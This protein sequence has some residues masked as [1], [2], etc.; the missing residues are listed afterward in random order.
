[1]SFQ[2]LWA[3]SYFKV[4]Q[5]DS[6]HIINIIL[7][8]MSVGYL[9]GSCSGSFLS[10]KL[11][12]CRT[13]PIRLALLLLLL[14]WSAITIIPY[15]LNTICFTFLM[16]LIGIS[17]GIIS[18][19]LY[20]IITDIIPAQNQGLALGIVNPSATFG[21]FIFQLITGFILESF[22]TGNIYD[23]NSFLIMME[24]CL[25]TLIISLFI[26]F[27]LK[28]TMQLQYEINN[29]KRFSLSNIKHKLQHLAPINKRHIN[30]L[31]YKRY[32][33]K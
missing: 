8:A 33:L 21:T 1:V 6:L 11:F 14:S 30:S 25:I 16:G 22:K 4:N 5:I 7:I 27:Y 13:T 31:L 28:E 12:K 23:S 10:D 19:I 2:G 3:I 20:S 18:P 9:I 26:S 32:M 15:N 29:I 17:T 24:F